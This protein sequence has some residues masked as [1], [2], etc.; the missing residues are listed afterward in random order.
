MPSLVEKL[1]QS[2]IKSHIP[3]GVTLELT[4]RCN[5]SCPFCYVD[6][7]ASRNE[8]ALSDWLRILEEMREAGTIHVTLTGGEPLLYRDC[9]II[10]R[11]AKEL[12]FITTFFSNGS[13]IDSA[14]ADELNAIKPGIIS[15]TIYGADAESYESYTG[16]PGSFRRFLAAVEELKAGGCEME[17]KW[18]A[19]TPQLVEETA[20]LIALAERLQVKWR[21]NGVIT[22][23]RTGDCPERISDEALSYFYRTVIKQDSLQDNLKT[24][25]ALAAGINKGKAPDTLVCLAAVSNCRINPEGRVFPCVDIDESLGDLRVE[26]FGEVWG[27]QARWQRFRSWRFRDFPDCLKCRYAGICSNLCPGQFK[28]ETGSYFTCARE[29]CRNTMTYLEAMKAYL[30]AEVGDDSNVLRQ[31]REAKTWSI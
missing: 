2:A 19:A 3:E 23:R 16:C 27:D 1:R 12:G 15:L 17:L 11:R 14:I 6:H 9:L 4:Y 20:S 31:E 8:L 26:T 30:K 21:A 18:N 10:L 29:V 24:A 5:Y 28:A 7:D 25:E 22:P 13:L